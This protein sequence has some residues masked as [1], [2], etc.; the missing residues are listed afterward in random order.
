MTTSVK[1][2]LKVLQLSDITISKTNPRKTFD[3]QA[4]SEL[5]LSI[6]EHGVLQP[7]LV[8]P[9]SN[10]KIELVCGERRYRAAKKAGLKEIPVNIRELTDDEAFE[11]QIIEN[12]ERKDVHPIEEAE[13]FQRMLDS[14]RY[15]L[16]DIA[17]KMVK[18]EAFITHR[19]KLNDLIPE[20]KQDFF[21][22]ELGI[23]HAF[24]IARLNKETQEGLF[25]FF[26]NRNGMQAYGTVK[27]LQAEINTHSM[28]LKNAPFAMDVNFKHAGPCNGCVNR[29][30]SNPELFPDVQD[31]DK[32]FYKNCFMAKKDEFVEQKT[33]EII[34]SGKDI[35]IGKEHWNNPPE[36]VKETAAKFKVPILKEYDDFSSSERDGY[37]KKKILITTGTNAGK[38]KQ[39]WVPPTN[40]KTSAENG[41]AQQIAEIE[42]KAVRA[43]ELDD[44]KIHAKIIAAMK[45]NFVNNKVPDYKL[46]PEFIETIMLYMAIQLVGIWYVKEDIK[47][48]KYGLKLEYESPEDLHEDFKKLSPAQKKQI[49]VIVMFKKYGNSQSSRHF[50]GKLI[51]KMAAA[52]DEIPV[53]EIEADQKAAADKR[54]ARTKE[55]IAEL[56]A[57]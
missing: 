46:D 10:K 8:R 11:L 43:L 31:Q 19:L 27:Q 16:A 24:E 51:R 33:L 44:E 17:A 23:G 38:V 21:H 28:D 30:S 41:T 7:I 35:L 52:N 37:E 47:K 13:A 32:C 1:S 4:L 12:L 9:L 39:V 50:E 55:R 6:K 40:K 3:E 56:K 53:A 15:T 26:K 45:G 54:I 5:S 34:T 2:E 25:K 20:I 57:K 42:R 18:P 14:G 49:M 22:G 48:L 36:A 29:S